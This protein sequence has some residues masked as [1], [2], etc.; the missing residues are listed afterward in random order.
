MSNFIVDELM[1]TFEEI[2]I[3]PKKVSDIDE[4]FLEHCLESNEYHLAQSFLINIYN[5]SKDEALAYVVKLKAKIAMRD[6]DNE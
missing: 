2:N 1:R 6:K 3:D 5:Y 4:G